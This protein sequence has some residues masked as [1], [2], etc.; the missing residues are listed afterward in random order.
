[1][2]SLDSRDVEITDIT[3]AVVVWLRNQLEDDAITASDN[4]LDIGGNSM[5]SMKVRNE[6]FVTFH[7][8]IDPV[9]LYEKSLDAAV[10][11]AAFAA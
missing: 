3:E 11:S 7:A 8:S 6:I 10:R 1:M 5:L 4:F 2:T 9:D